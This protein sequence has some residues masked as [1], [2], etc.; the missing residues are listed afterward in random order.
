MKFAEGWSNASEDFRKYYQSS[1]LAELL[2]LSASADRKRI[3]QSGL[4]L[5]VGWYTARNLAENQP[6]E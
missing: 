6:P 3:W 5:N 2:A 1:L 4:P